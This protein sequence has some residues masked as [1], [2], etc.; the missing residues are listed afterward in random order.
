MMVGKPTRAPYRLQQRD[1]LSADP[2]FTPETLR[3]I[4]VD[5]LGDRYAP[6]GDAETATLCGILNQWHQWFYHAQEARK[7]NALIAKAQA[8]LDTLAETVPEVL[9]ELRKRDQGRDPFLSRQMRQTQALAAYLQRN[10]RGF[11]QPDDLPDQ[12]TDWRWLAKVLPADIETCL[13]PS[14]PG[15]R[16]GITKTGPLARILEAVIPCLTGEQVTA[17]AVGTQLKLLGPGDIGLPNIS[18]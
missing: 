8:A 17:A 11:L 14:N 7:F 1:M 6:P 18:G 12:V 4:L 13:Q 2:P 16:G 9:D 3:T 10:G 15:Y 5:A